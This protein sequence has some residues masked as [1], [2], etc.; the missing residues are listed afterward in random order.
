MP[1]TFWSVLLMIAVGWLLVWGG[2]DW[3]QATFAGMLVGVGVDRGVTR[4]RRRSSQP[5][6]RLGSEK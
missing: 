2:L 1:H 5:A 3:L 6:H 4:W